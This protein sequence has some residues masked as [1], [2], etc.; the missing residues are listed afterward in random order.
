MY[1]IMIQRLILEIRS[2][3]SEDTGIVMNFKQR[4]QVSWN[5]KQ[6]C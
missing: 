4:R 1:L 5:I 6:L 2:Q 3:I